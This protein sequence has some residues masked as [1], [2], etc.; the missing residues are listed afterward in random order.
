[1]FLFD[2]DELPDMSLGDDLSEEQTTENFIDNSVYYDNV[3]EFSTDTDATMYT[4]WTETPP[5][6]SAAQSTVYLLEIR[7]ILLI[8]LLGYFCLVFYSKIKNLFINFF[9]M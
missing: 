5:A 8:F 7:N 9:D 6:S 3:I 1:M 2:V 4:V